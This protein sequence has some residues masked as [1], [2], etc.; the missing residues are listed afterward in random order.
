MILAAALLVAQ[1]KATLVVPPPTSRTSDSVVLRRAAR[2]VDALRRDLAADTT[3]LWMP[4][5]PEG[6]PRSAS[7]AFLPARFM[8]TVSADTLVLGRVPITVR[9]INVE[10][11]EIVARAQTSIAGDS[12]NVAA[13]MAT[14]VSANVRA[15][16]RARL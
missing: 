3:V 9:V 16:Y 7:G 13:D 10:T 2:F 14:M 11:T 4:V 8:V 1:A 5:G 6:R 15:R 12:R